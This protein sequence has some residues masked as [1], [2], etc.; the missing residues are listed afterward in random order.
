M[1]LNKQQVEPRNVSLSKFLDRILLWEFG[2][3]DR[4]EE[5]RSHPSVNVPH[6]FPPVK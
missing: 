4:L 3:R 1:A 5:S 2:R 6:Y